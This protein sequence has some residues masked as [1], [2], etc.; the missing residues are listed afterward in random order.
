MLHIQI[1]Y[2]ADKDFDPTAEQGVSCPA[3]AAVRT[4]TPVP[5][6]RTHLVD[7][8]REVFDGERDA[9]IFA[10]YE[11]DTAL[12]KLKGNHLDSVTDLPLGIQEGL[13]EITANLNQRLNGL[14]IYRV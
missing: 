11:S 2:P 9:D 6:N 13:Q 1:P 7:V 8:M 10:R 12:P 5:N 3:F 14:A 4:A